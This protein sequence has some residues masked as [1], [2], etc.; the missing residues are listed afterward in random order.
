M[1]ADELR[2]EIA[3]LERYP[4]RSNTQ[5]ARLQALRDESADRDDRRAR[6]RTAAGNPNAGERAHNSPVPGRDR[7]GGLIDFGP[8]LIG[9]ARRVIDDAHTRRGLP[10]HGAERVERLLASGIP[11]QSE[12]CARWAASVGSEAYEAAFRKVF[13]S[14]HFGHLEFTEPER[15][16]WA[17]GQ[18]AVRALGTSPGSAG[19]F[20]VPLTL[21]PTVLLTNDGAIN[22]LRQLARVEQIAT[23]TWQGVTSAGVSSAWV[24]EAT[25]FGDDSPTLAQPEVTPLKGGSFVPFTFEVG[26]DWA[27]IRTELARLLVDQAGLL[28]AGAF[29]TGTGVAQPTGVVTALTGTASDISTAAAG[30]LADEDVYGLQNDLPPRFQGRAQWA[31]SLPIMNDLDQRETGNGAKKFPGVAEGRLLRRPVNEVSDMSSTVATGQHVM[32]YG[33]FHEFLIVDRIGTTIEL[34]PHLFGANRRPTGERGMLLWFRS[35]SDVLV[36]NAFR[37]LTIG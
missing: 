28:Q 30:V 3:Q 14:P 25:E 29:T 16:A 19:G 24:P 6:L 1:H 21:D 36:P 33:D 22:P 37:M 4:R 27:N 20:A 7:E 31:M 9:R 12:L 13:A 35:G 26:M 17:R 23:T 10:D 15:E 18:D 2:D 8:E 11:G 5:D 34:V 32:L